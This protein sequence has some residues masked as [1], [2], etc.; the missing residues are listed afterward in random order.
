MI[1]TNARIVE[2]GTEL[3]L[4]VRSAQVRTLDQSPPQIERICG[5]IRRQKGLPATPIEG[6]PEIFLLTSEPIQSFELHSGDLHVRIESKQKRRTLKFEREEDAPL[7]ARLLQQKLIQQTNQRTDLWTLDSPRIFYEKNPRTKEKIDSYR[8]YGVTAIP[9]EGVGVGITVEITTAFFSAKSVAWFFDEEVSGRERERRTDL[10]ERLSKRQDG[11]KGTLLYDRGRRRRGKC[12]FERY[13]EGVRCGDPVTGRSFRGKSYDSLLDYYQKRYGH[14]DV[15]PE[16]PVAMVSFRNGPNNVPVS[17]R[18]LRLRV[19]NDMLPDSFRGSVRMKPYDRRKGTKAFWR[20]LGSKPFGREDLGLKKG[21]WAPSKEKRAIQVQTPA[22]EF[23]DQQVAEAP[24]ITGYKE[25]KDHYRSRKRLLD[26]NGCFDTPHTVT[27]TIHFCV[28]EG[29]GEEAARRLAREVTGRLSKWAGYPIEPEISLYQNRTTQLARLSEEDPSMVVFVFD[30]DRRAAYH[31]IEHEL[32]SARVKRITLQKLTEAIGALKSA[33]EGTGGNNGQSGRRKKKWNHLVENSA[34]DVL[35]QLDC[36]P[37]TI[38]EE[39]FHEAQLAIDVGPRRRSFA[40][41]LLVCRDGESSSASAPRQFVLDTRVFPKSDSNKEEISRAVL[42]KKIVSLFKDNGYE[43]KD[44][45]LRSLLVLRDGRECGEELQAIQDARRT[46]AEAGL[47]ESEARVEVVDFRK[48]TGNGV[49]IWDNDDG[50][51]RQAFEGTAVLLDRQTA[52][53]IN[54]G[55]P[56]LHQGTASPLVLK[57]RTEGG[58][59]EEV[60]HDIHTCSHLNWTSPNIAQGLPLAIK[61][62]DDELQRRA[63]QEILRVQ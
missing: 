19:M 21:F 36:V 10:F 7:V 2:P 11:Q 53:V 34:L 29:V 9:I 60:V 3:K 63:A 5:K 14:L 8:R 52:V 37:W 47:I 56:T 35:Q 28:P 15:S 18:L 22:L 32:S 54:T 27:R 51:I 59:I 25:R 44:C 1:E 31:I 49:R 48:G 30:D 24:S 17:A 12:Y 38:R 42:R 62:T 40:L 57:A 6:G 55:A 43:L 46:L 50:Y 16:D 58:N 4:S 45:P 13:A 39:L 61:R 26:K 41:S 20:K 33:E 23:G